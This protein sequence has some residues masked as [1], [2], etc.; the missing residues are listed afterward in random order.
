MREKTYCRPVWRIAC[1]M[2]PTKKKSTG[3]FLGEA[4]SHGRCE[5][6]PTNQKSTGLFLG[7]ANSHAAICDLAAWK[8]W[9]QSLK[10]KERID[11]INGKVFNAEKI[12]L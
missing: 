11:F 7:K 5:M 3:L 4:N 9:R 10:S 8:N 1:E 2:L 6:L 12:K